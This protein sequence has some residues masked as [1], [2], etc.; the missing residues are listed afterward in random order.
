[1]D[2]KRE[3]DKIMEDER[4]VHLVNDKYDNFKDTWAG[5]LYYSSD[6]STD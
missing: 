5:W 1:M 6:I 4:R 3:V 2:W